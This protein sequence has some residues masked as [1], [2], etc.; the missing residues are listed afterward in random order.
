[1]KMLESFSELKPP[2]KAAVALA[3]GGGIMAAMSALF[4]PASIPIIAGGLALIAVLF[5]AYKFALKWWDKRKAS[6]MEKAIKSS[7]ATTPTGIAEPAK[8][9]RLDDLRKNFDTGV[10]KF[11]AAGK[12]L[13]SLPW[14][15][16]VG[17]PGSGKTEAIRHC[18][19]G[20]PPGLQ[21][22]LQGAGGTVNMNWWF[23]NHAVILDTA[24]RL[25]FEEV[26]PSATNE[27]QEFLKLLKKVRPN[28][29]I[30]GMLLVIPAESLIRDTA[31]AIER[32]AGKI[33]AQ[34]DQIQRVLGVRFPVFVVVTKCDL[35]NGFRE[36]F[37]EVTDPTLQHQIMGWSNPS[38]LDTPFNPEF[39][40]Q[41][42][43]TV[44]E[45]LVRR[46]M[47]LLQDPVN[48][49][50]PAASRTA[51][52]D[53]LFAFPE[54]LM[55]IGPRLRRYLEMIFVAGEWSAKPL[56]LRGIYFTS[57]M[58]EGTALDAD[59]ADALGMPVE[60]LPEGRVWE[61]ERAYFLR[62]LFLQKV[63]R[64]RGLVTRAS[65]TSSHL[66]QRRAIVYGTGI[67]GSV[68]LL[69][70]TVLASRDLSQSVDKPSK[71]W[72]AVGQTYMKEERK[73]G[74]DNANFPGGDYFNPI[75]MATNTVK[76]PP[77]SYEG[78]RAKDSLVQIAV[79]EKNGTPGRFPV[80]V[81]EQAEAK[82][83]TPFVFSLWGMIAG[84]GSLNFAEQGRQE[85]AGVIVEESVLRPT[86]EAARL[87]LK[88]D[89]E[90]AEAAPA[91]G[92]DNA[93]AL[94]ELVRLEVASVRG[95]TGRTT[96]LANLV[97]YV[98]RPDAG[99]TGSTSR[100]N[101]S[102]DAV[103]LQP[104]IDWTY[105]ATGGK[106]PWPPES[107][108]RDD[109]AALAAQGVD[110]Y[111]VKAASGDAAGGMGDVK[112]FVDALRTL[113]TAEKE[114]HEVRAKPTTE[115]AAWWK[116]KYAAVKA[117]G[118][119]AKELTTVVEGRTLAEAFSQER[120]KHID[121]VKSRF[122]IV[123]DELT[124]VF[125]DD[126]ESVAS[127]KAQSGK[128][129]VNDDRVAALHS[130]RGA[131]D[132][133]LA[134][135]VRDDE[136][137]RE[138]ENACKRADLVHLRGG[139]ATQQAFQVRLQMYALANDVFTQG[140][141]ETK[142]VIGE[143]GSRL[144]GIVDASKQGG[145]N[146]ERQS[147]NLAEIAGDA[148]GAKD[149]GKLGAD[150]K[151]SSRQIAT[152]AGKQRAEGVVSAWIESLAGAPE[153]F[154]AK[155]AEVAT[156]NKWA[157][158][159]PSV[160]MT[161]AK[162]GPINGSFEPQ[163][164]VAVLKD[165]DAVGKLVSGAD[166]S[167]GLK[168]DPSGP[169][170]ERAKTLK[171]AA[172]AYG[173]RYVTYWRNAVGRDAAVRVF[174]WAELIEFM[175]GGPDMR[176]FNKPL[177]DLGTIA[178]DALDKVQGL[179][180]LPDGATP[181]ASAQQIKSSIAN[182]SDPTFTAP[183]D[184]L[185]NN[186]ATLAPE[187]GTARLT[188]LASYNDGKLKPAFV[189]TADKTKEADFIERYWA[190]FSLRALTALAGE[191]GGEVPRAIQFLRSKQRFPIVAPGAG[192]NDGALSI[193]ELMEVREKLK[194]AED[195]ASRG[196]ASGGTA[197]PAAGQRPLPLD[198]QDQVDKLRGTKAIDD[199]DR[200]LIAQIKIALD[201]LPEKP[202]QRL[203]CKIEKAEP[204]GVT[205]NATSTY[206]LMSI[207]P[208]G[209]PAGKGKYVHNSKDPELLAESVTSIDPVGVVINFFFDENKGI[210]PTAGIS[211]PGPWTPQRLLLD[212]RFTSDVRGS[213]KE[214]YVNVKV[215]GDRSV[216]LKLTFE[217]ELPDVKKWRGQ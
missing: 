200:A 48:T 96:K 91:A 44:Q 80:E 58:R 137:V 197:A 11:R 127:V 16:L 63:F 57:S 102:A 196:S 24:G 59:L 113:E 27:W 125:G 39:I 5:L 28:C 213:G 81:K 56:F 2:V 180:T 88:D 209:A 53:A 190:D 208:T 38:S 34:L 149:A 1:M 68:L 136:A 163:A 26:D 32:K 183:I 193:E 46:R 8:R 76:A 179:V 10:E 203:A 164:A 145:E 4:G 151:E 123:L 133:G 195:A 139:G 41:H 40:D 19:V 172:G 154:D 22:Q 103:V 87:R 30:N 47:T 66:K 21:D 186:W 161:V 131:L 29:P 99:T 215:A 75:V 108:V 160:P 176:T 157:T 42:L 170:A 185:F 204:A 97:P 173:Q 82:I 33:A 114:L 187:A 116:D 169:L 89:L 201:G 95:A 61:R 188:V 31:D 159:R 158:M 178:A 165:C 50:N 86:I 134:D 25:M 128:D 45:R 9:A 78:A 199:S 124:P 107:L 120:K 23:T 206:R 126:G 144:T 93:K 67:I 94:A 14:Y 210:D 130:L 12:N 51:Q 121:R 198:V 15:A 115:Q 62:D 49:E 52:V 20:F 110:R 191:A 143:L 55:K 90:A 119:K 111:V 141:D 194:V 184:G 140:A 168:L 177:L 100:D 155:V 69:G 98:F 18:N 36:F 182:L 162:A 6:P 112:R 3:S 205:S 211:I 216:W 207:T 83:R 64:E 152:L 217:K 35:I 105:S 84:K 77:F 167:G 109:T 117:A 189:W 171:D 132:K 60:A 192:G 156:A 148:P 13:Y 17:E 72:E 212:S 214:W 174:S 142:V 135:A 150:A 70:F 166:S 146:V 175:R 54:S 71:F 74:R 7:A 138:T 122:G 43:R 129:K 104:V 118:D 101:A 37:D 79:S 153:Q 85:A 73:T 65:N 147:K 202:E 181:V 106:R 92:D